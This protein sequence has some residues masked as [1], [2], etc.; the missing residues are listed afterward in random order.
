MMVMVIVLI[1]MVGAGVRRFAF[2]LQPI[3]LGMSLR[4]PFLLIVSG[5]IKLTHL[6]S[7]SN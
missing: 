1:R 7:K 3:L 2:G 6:G 5:R 4:T